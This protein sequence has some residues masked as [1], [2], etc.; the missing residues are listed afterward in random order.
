VFDA[1]AAFVLKARYFADIF[2]ANILEG[3]QIMALL[4]GS[5]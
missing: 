3:I 4:L 1:I 2:E 5:G